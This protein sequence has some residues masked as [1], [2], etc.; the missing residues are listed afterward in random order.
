MTTATN[1]FIR[2]GDDSLMIW[3]SPV[4]EINATVCQ[5]YNGG[6]V[7]LGWLNNSPGDNGLLDGIY[8]VKTDWQRPTA[9][10]W[11]ALPPTSSGALNGQNNAVFASLMSPPTSLGQVSPPVYRNIIVEYPPLVLFS[12]KIVPPVNCPPQGGLH[13]KQPCNRARCL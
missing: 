7:N 9:N 11:N 5:N 1:V 2:S 8:V 13:R 10:D 4:T 12:L 6:V 3:G